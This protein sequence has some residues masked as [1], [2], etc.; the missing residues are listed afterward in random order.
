M[1][2]VCEQQRLKR[3]RNS[4]DLSTCEKMI[5]FIGNQEKNKHKITMR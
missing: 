1:V 5:S 2:I 4:N 3:L